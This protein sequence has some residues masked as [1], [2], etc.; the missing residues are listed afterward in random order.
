MLVPTVIG[1][2]QDGVES[3][4]QL[5][6]GVLE[7]F[8]FTTPSSSNSLVRTGNPNLNQNFEENLVGLY[9]DLTFSYKDFLF[10]NAVG[11][12]DWSSTLERENNSLFYPGASISFVPTSA[13]DG[14][15]GDVLNYVKF[16]LGYGSSAGFPTPFNT[17]DVLSLNARSL[18]DLNGNVVSSNTVSNTL[19]NRDLKP[20]RVEEFE[21][22]LD[23]RLFNRLNLNVSLFDK[24]TTDLITNRTLDSSTGFTSTTVNIGEIQS[25]GVE[26]DFDIDV[27]KEYENN[28][29][30]NLAG[31]FSTIETTVT[32]LAEGTENILLTDAISGEAANYAVEGRPFGVFLGTTVLKDDAGNRLVNDAG[33]YLVD[34]TISEIG[35]PNPDWTAALIPTITYKNFTLSANIQYRHGGDI[36][37]L[38]T[39]ALIGR[40]TVDDDNPI[41]RESQF[42]LP[43][44]KQS[45]GLPNDVAIS[46][47]ELGFNTFFGGG[48]NEFTVFD[49]TTIRLQEASLGY[50]VPAKMLKD[51]PFGSL[52]FKV[53]GSNLWF[54]AVNFPENIRYDSNSSST[55]VGNGQGID[56]FTGPSSRRY[57]FTLRATF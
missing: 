43:G 45:D 2:N 52:S 29:G 44:L 20:E 40:G 39:A 17:R 8:N 51:T 57:G 53:S 55:G 36:Y 14:I 47:T 15:Q 49:G 6:F 34:N 27:L 31:N 24:T 1:M 56:F 16:R 11:R 37:S 13:F 25:Q 33:R 30:I 46:A 35:D 9:A 42:L 19:G 41:D 48:I 12:N 32:K 4:G 50:S 22:G 7:H 3:Q 23:T 26:V 18:V 54:K 28:I 5:V 10:V 21:V 38:T